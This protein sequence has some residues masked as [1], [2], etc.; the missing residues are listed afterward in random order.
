[1]GVEAGADQAPERPLIILFGSQD[2]EGRCH[3]VSLLIGGGEVFSA[4]DFGV[5]VSRSGFF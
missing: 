1:V 5:K 3:C 4:G 2:V